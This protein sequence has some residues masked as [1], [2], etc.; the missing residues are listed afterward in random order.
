M[1]YSSQTSY[2]LPIFQTEDKPSWIDDF[3][4]AMNNID[5]NLQSMYSNYSSL[6][7]QMANKAN[8]YVPSSTS[9]YYPADW[10]GNQAILSDSPQYTGLGYKK[11]RTIATAV[12]LDWSTAGNTSFSA[13]FTVKI[14]VIYTGGYGSNG[15]PIVF[16]LHL[17]AQSANINKWN[18]PV[19][20][21]VG[22]NH[23]GTVNLRVEII[24]D[25]TDIKTVAK[26]KIY[27]NNMIGA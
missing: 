1:S 10:A 6:S 11:R 24:S 9:A 14:D 5:S 13:D 26:P 27:F 8:L 15:Y 21:A 3:N 2:G 12:E 25:N 20:L 17:T 16:N 7:S 23:T 18:L 22:T 19:I 4:A